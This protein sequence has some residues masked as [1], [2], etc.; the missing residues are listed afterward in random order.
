MGTPTGSFK[1][2]LLGALAVTAVW[3]LA[4]AGPVAAAPPDSGAGGPGAKVL[5]PA[6][7][8]ESVFSISADLYLTA[9]VLTFA[10]G[11][12]ALYRRV[13]RGAVASS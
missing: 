3:I 12:L 5:V 6:I 2:R 9:I 7:E 13:R 10:V 4:L 1:A 8:P 11:A